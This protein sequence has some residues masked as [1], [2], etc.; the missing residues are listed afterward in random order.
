MIDIFNGTQA[1]ATIASS[2]L[3]IF[4][5]AV[6]MMFGAVIIAYLAMDYVH[7]KHIENISKQLTE[8]ATFTVQSVQSMTAVGITAMQGMDITDKVLGKPSP[9][10]E[11][12]AQ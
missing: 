3:S 9:Q 6:L 10:T 7:Y 12:K 8:T 2:D 4:L 5:T 11:K 1:I